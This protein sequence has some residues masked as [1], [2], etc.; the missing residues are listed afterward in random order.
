[1]NCMSVQ[2]EK[3]NY[4]QSSQAYQQNNNTSRV[5]LRSCL[6]GEIE[7][8]ECKIYF[9]D[10]SLQI[11]NIQNVKQQIRMEMLPT[12]MILGT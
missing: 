4:Q 3:K 2:Q 10:F 12:H 5:G 11:K 7:D 8:T 1:M 9:F 6:R